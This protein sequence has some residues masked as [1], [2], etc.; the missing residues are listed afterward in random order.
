MSNDYKNIVSVKN[1]PLYFD[2]FKERKLSSV[3]IVSLS[4][5]NNRDNSKRKNQYFYKRI[6]C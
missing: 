1:L 2:Y 3:E 4:K 5:S 6:C